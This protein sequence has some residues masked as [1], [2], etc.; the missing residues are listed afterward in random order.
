M[1]KMADEKKSSVTEILMKCEK[2]G[3]RAV[4]SEIDENEGYCPG[5][6]QIFQPLDDSAMNKPFRR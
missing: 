3:Y 4:Q 2:C 1:V 5:C 6:K